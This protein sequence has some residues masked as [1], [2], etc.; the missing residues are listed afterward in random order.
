MKVILKEN[1]INLGEMGEEVSVTDGYARNYLIPRDLA[2]PTATGSARE[3]EHQKRQI[4]SREDK[5]RARLAE[6]A[7]KMEQ[8]TIEVTA[9]AG[10]GESDRIYGSVTSTM[11]AERLNELGFEVSKKAVQLEEPIKSLGLFVVPVRLMNGVTPEVKV[12]VMPE[13]PEE[14][15]AEEAQTEAAAAAEAPAGENKTESSAE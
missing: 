12:S 15:P 8:V 1:V 2:V 13:E 14:T 4:K 3:I 9:R 11:I 5:E 6:I 10:A 7:K